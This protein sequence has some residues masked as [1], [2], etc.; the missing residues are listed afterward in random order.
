[1]L[2]TMRKRGCSLRPNCLGQASKLPCHT[3]DRRGHPALPLACRARCEYKQTFSWDP[4][5]S[6]Y[7]INI[8]DAQTKTGIDL[9]LNLPHFL[10]HRFTNRELS[11]SYGEKL[12]FLELMQTVQ[13]PCIRSS[14]ARFSPEGPTPTYFCGSD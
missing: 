10:H 4:L 2:R 1:M 12:D 11:L 9:L 6:H 14:R 13:S 3:C 8:P 5:C 7:R